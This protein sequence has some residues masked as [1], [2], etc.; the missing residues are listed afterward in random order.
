LKLGICG[1]C[2]VDHLALVSTFRGAHGAAGDCA[3]GRRIYRD[4]WGDD[5]I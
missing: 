3:E 2:F 5:G 1:A 4:K